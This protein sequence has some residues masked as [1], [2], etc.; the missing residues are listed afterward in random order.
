[1]ANVDRP[2]GFT[3]VGKLGGGD[4]SMNRYKKDASASRVY[5]GD[6]VILEADGNVAVA[7]A[8]DRLL[9]V[10]AQDSTAST[11]EDL[12]VI[13]DPD[14]IYSCQ[15]DGVGTT[16]AQT[17]VGNNVDILATTGNTTTGRSA[18]ELDISTVGTASAQF[19][20]VDLDRTPGNDWGANARILVRIN[21][22]IFNQATAAG[23]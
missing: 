2:M 21:E 20:I 19:R 13:D 11:A 23:I 22:H 10:S 16:S 18:H 4:V 14:A 3:L 5:F 17:H 9:G 8:G 1:M 12:L 6:T 7:A 15:D